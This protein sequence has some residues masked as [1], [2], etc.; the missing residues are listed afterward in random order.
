MAGEPTREW[1][2]PSP[3]PSDEEASSSSKESTSYEEEVLTPRPEKKGWGLQHEIL[4]P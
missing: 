3:G 4:A 2:K 1:C